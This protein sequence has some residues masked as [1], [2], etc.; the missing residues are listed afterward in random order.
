MEKYKTVEEL[1]QTAFKNFLQEANQLIVGPDRAGLHQT[2][3]GRAKIT[4]QDRAEI[5]VQGRVGLSGVDITGGQGRAESAGQGRTGQ[6]RERRAEITEQGRAS[7]SHLLL[8]CSQFR[9]GGWLSLIRLLALSW[10]S[11]KQL[12][13]RQLFSVFF[14]H[15]FQHLCTSKQNNTEIV[16]RDCTVLFHV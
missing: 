4:K 13:V 16:R 14:R 9:L 5:I 11:F 10:V 3:Q 2:G 1:V 7:H 15:H 8:G 12:H 6:G